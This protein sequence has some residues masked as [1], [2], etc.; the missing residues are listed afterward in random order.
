MESEC[1]VVF[2]SL[3]TFEHGRGH[4][5]CSG[6]IRARHVTGNVLD[7]TSLHLLVVALPARPQML[8]S[9]MKLF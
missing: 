2:F 6:E 1:R 8:I 9:K 7:V 3:P 4:K 5:L